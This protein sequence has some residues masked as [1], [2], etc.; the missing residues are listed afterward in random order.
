MAAGAASI[1]LRNDETCVRP[2]R[3]VGW[4]KSPA[5]A[6]DLSHC[7]AR[8]CPRGQTGPDRT[9]GKG[10]G[11][12]EVQVPA[13]IPANS[14]SSQRCTFAHPKP[15][16]P[17]PN[18]HL[19]ATNILSHAGKFWMIRRFTSARGIPANAGAFHEPCGFKP[20]RPNNHRTK[21]TCKSPNSSHKMQRMNSQGPTVGSSR[22]NPP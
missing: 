18:R 9:A 5:A 2:R 14:R 21:T 13:S 15:A 11:Q 10:A 4:V 22:P 6:N 1:T 17:E 19:Q 7:L 8:L 16:E 12:S 20:F 3:I